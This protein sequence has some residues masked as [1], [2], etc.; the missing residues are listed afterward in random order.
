MQ[1]GRE[2]WHQRNADRH[3]AGGEDELRRID[4]GRADDGGVEARANEV[5]LAHL[6]RERGRPRREAHRHRRHDPLPERH[7]GRH[8]PLVLV[9]RDRHG[10][11]RVEAARH[12]ERGAEH[13]DAQREDRDGHSD[14]AQH[15]HA[16]ASN[17]VIRHESA[18]PVISSTA[19]AGR[20]TYRPSGVDRTGAMSSPF[21]NAR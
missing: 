3:D 6:R 17:R 7:L 20:S 4:L 1:R 8:E 11:D 16:Q 19:A 2:Q 21:A 18:N 15:L 14:G 5:A 9:A 10:A 12:Q 13:R